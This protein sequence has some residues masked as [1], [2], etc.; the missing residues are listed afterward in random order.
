MGN[1][2][3]I[4]DP[5]LDNSVHPHACGEHNYYSYF[6]VCFYGS[7][8]RLW[9]TSSPSVYVVP[10]SRFIPTPVGNIVLSGETIY[11]GTVHPHACGE[12]LSSIKRMTFNTGSSP[13]LWGTYPASILP[14]KD[15][16]FIPTP[17]GNIAMGDL[18]ERL[19]AVHPH[20]CGEHVK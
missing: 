9:G 14:F 15:T 19:G 20:A 7:S 13:R 2:L 11:Q 4:Q 8:P 5:H 18:S 16:R 12:H 10:S 6:A 3:L 17:V 1:I